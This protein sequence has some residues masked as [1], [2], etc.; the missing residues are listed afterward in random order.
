M[1]VWNKHECRKET[2]L[3]RG[4]LWC[5]YYWHF[6][7]SLFWKE[8]WGHK[9]SDHGGQEHSGV[10][11]PKPQSYERLRDCVLSMLCPAFSSMFP[12]GKEEERMKQSPKHRN[13]LCAKLICISSLCGVTWTAGLTCSALF[14][15]QLL[16]SP[17]VWSC[18][19]QIFKLFVSDC[20]GEVVVYKFE[21]KRV[22]KSVIGTEPCAKGLFW[23]SGNTL[24]CGLLK[25]LSPRGWGSSLKCTFKLIHENN[26]QEE[27]I[28]LLCWY[29]GDAWSIC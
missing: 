21:A 7:E 6:Y 26:G 27:C 22:W 14:W 5:N 23:G 20:L 3:N 17:D 11:S 10:K 4:L 24:P 8:K 15:F 28:I 29:S 2:G 1:L 9:F 13:M 18:V 12:L 16:A 25:M 19:M